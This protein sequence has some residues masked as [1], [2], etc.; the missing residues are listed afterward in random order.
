MAQGGGRTVWPLCMASCNSSRVPMSLLHGYF[1][2]CM[3]S[4]MHS[5]IREYGPL[6][7]Q[8]FH[9]SILP[10]CICFRIGFLTCKSTARKMS[11]ET[12]PTPAAITASASMLLRCS[13]QPTHRVVDSVDLHSPALLVEVFMPSQVLAR[14]LVREGVLVLHC[15]PNHHRT[16]VSLLLTRDREV[17]LPVVPRVVSVLMPAPGVYVAVTDALQQLDDNHLCDASEITTASA[18]KAMSGKHNSIKWTHTCSMEL[19]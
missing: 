7:T 19:Q 2:T 1:M 6:Y 10:A 5:A 8:S 11:H 16:H 4:G 14:P 13:Q 18:C 17:Q 12:R 3:Y 15:K 9:S